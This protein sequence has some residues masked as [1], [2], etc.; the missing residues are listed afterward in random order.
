M[1]DGQTRDCG[2]RPRRDTL[3][4]TRRVIEIHKP[5]SIPRAAIGILDVLAAVGLLALQ[6][7][8]CSVFSFVVYMMA[9]GVSGCGTPGRTCHLQL[10][11]VAIYITP[12]SGAVIFLSSAALAVVSGVRRRRLW[13]WPAVGNGL[14]FVAS[15]TAMVLMSVAIPT[16]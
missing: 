16:S 9:T 4:P 5:D 15:L 6:V 10:S 14:L 7:A 1:Y 8:A 12:I 13:M 2:T 3:P 11:T